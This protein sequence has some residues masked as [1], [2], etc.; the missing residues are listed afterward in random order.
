MVTSHPSHRIWLHPI[1]PIG[2]GYIPDA[3]HKLFTGTKLFTGANVKSLMG[4]EIVNT[5][6]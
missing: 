4:H 5:F 2:Y 6:K 1:H 3:R